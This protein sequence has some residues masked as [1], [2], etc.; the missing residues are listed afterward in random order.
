[1]GSHLYPQ[2]RLFVLISQCDKD[3]G[4]WYIG[5]SDCPLLPGE[6]FVSPSHSPVGIPTKQR[7]ALEPTTILASCGIKSYTVLSLR[8][9]DFNIKCVFSLVFQEIDN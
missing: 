5:S 8:T 3:N 9:P 6:A 7:E 2:W 4:R 1:M